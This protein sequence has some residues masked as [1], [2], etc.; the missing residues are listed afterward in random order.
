MTIERALTIRVASLY[1]PAILVALA[2]AVNR[3][4]R[5]RAAGTLLAIAWNLP[6]LLFVN[7]VAQRTG[8][9]AF[10]SSPASIAGVPAELL[11]GW[12]LL[13]GAVPALL[14]PR[15]RIVFVVAVLAIADLVLMPLSQPVVVLGD[16]WLIGECVALLV[17]LV[18][19]Q[20]LARWTADDRR[21]ESRAALQVITFGATVLWLVPA[22]VFELKGGGWSPL[23]EGWRRW[24]GLHLQLAAVPALLGVS[25]VQ[26]FA[27]RGRGTP[28]PFDPPRKLVTSG[29]YAYVSNPMQLAAALVM[30]AWG[31]ILLSPWIALGGVMSVAYSLG[32]AEP[33]EQSDLNARFGRPWRAYRKH[34]RAWIPRW[35]PYHAAEDDSRSKVPPA[36]LYVAATCGPCSE[37]ARWF[38]AQ[39]PRGLEIVAAELH[40]TRDLNRITYDPNDGGADVMGVAAIA[41]ALEHIHLGWA[42]IAWLIRLPGMVQVIQLLADASGAEPRLVKRAKVSSET[43]AA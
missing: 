37:V 5:A 13:W 17:A 41:A 8:W 42:I 25:A 19:A 24:G 43:C 29:P 16:R 35:R 33:D 2:W 4:S 32:L 14:M 38:T 12:A 6:T 3:P 1:A 30:L 31:I 11:L 34:I 15:L 36:R 20:L 7:V 40:P 21:L 27:L 39:R 10:A 28:I 23:L 9:W 18:P 22:V 26:E